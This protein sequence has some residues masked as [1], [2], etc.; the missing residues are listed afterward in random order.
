[1]LKLKES[2]FKLQ[3]GFKQLKC[4]DW[5]VIDSSKRLFQIWLVLSEATK[6]KVQ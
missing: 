3:C 2:I 5:G 1:M 4:C 6:M